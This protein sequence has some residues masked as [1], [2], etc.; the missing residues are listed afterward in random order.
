MLQ[1]FLLLT[2]SSLQATNSTP[3]DMSA[4]P[5]AF[6]ARG[7]VLDST[8]PKRPFDELRVDL[9]MRAVCDPEVGE[10]ELELLSGTGAQQ[11]RDRYFIRR[12]RIF[13]IDAAGAEIPAAPHADVSPAAIA[14][15]HPAWIEDAR[16]WRRENV[17]V[18]LTELLAVNDVLWRIES[19]AAGRVVQL[20]RSTFSDEFGDGIEELRFERAQ[21]SAHCKSVSV[22]LSGR[23]IA[24]FDFDA[25]LPAA[26]PV[27]PAGL[28]QRDA[29]R[30]VAERD[31]LLTE[32]APHAFA[33]DLPTLDSRV[34][35]FEFADY[36]VVYEGAFGSAVC[37]PIAR[38]LERR[39]AKPVRYFAFSH[40][41]AQY[42]SG[43][44]TWIHAGAIV[45]VPP[46]SEP[47]IRAIALAPFTRR[48]DALARELKPARVETIID[49]RHFEDEFN[50]L[51]IYNVASA[52]TDEYLICHLP[53]AKLAFSGDLL[54]YRPG[55]PVTGR[56]KL[57]HETLSNLG[58]DYQRIY[59]TWPLASLGTKNVVEAAELRE[60]ARD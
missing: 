14:A 34:F 48:P 55:Q 49:R 27:L 44:R 17:F 23:E 9:T 38:A 2:F 39:F 32:I 60:A 35:V 51:D 40:L 5:H 19:D 26:A 33:I 10:L 30:V 58:L 11:E 45:L 15:L 37:D 22:L 31:V 53:R 52:H 59:C 28:R 3:A 8:H 42:V 24:H 54:F 13:Q 18:G 1:L 36:L 21:G 20:S 25:A 41:H 29:V 12:G 4:V 6:V 7:F 16:R 57:F 47:L 46:T 50:A 43:V 56:S